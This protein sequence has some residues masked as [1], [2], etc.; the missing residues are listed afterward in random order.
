MIKFIIL[1]ALASTMTLT[2]GFTCS[3]G[4]PEATPAA[5]EMPAEETEVA[6]DEMMEEATETT[7]ETE[8]T[9][10]PVTQ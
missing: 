5:Q 9:Q 10:E 8:T 1:A 3:K 7:E 4:T 2:A 6:T